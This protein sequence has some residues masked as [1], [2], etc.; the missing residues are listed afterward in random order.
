MSQIIKY[1]FGPATQVALSADGAQAIAIDNDLTMVDGVSVPATGDRTINLTIPDDIDEGARI[2]F[3][4]KTAATEN[5]IFGTGITGA[6][7]VGVAGKTKTVEA[8]FNGT[9]F[10]V[11]GTPG[12]ID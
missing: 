2:V 9:V 6:T 4:L 12:Q 10:E 3:R 5:T 7:I 1:P 11:I 8:V